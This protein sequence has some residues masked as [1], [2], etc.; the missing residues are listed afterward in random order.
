MSKSRRPRFEADGQPS[1][2]GSDNDSKELW[3]RQVAE[4]ARR[5]ADELAAADHP[6]LRQLHADLTDLEARLTETDTEPPE[7]AD[8]RTGN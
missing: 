8:P 1:P 5:A 6:E 7:A 4:A 2:I 3:R